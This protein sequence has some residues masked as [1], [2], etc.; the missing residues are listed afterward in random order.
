MFKFPEKLLEIPLVSNTVSTLYNLTS[1]LSSYLETPKTLLSSCYSNIHY[2]T[3]G[4]ILPNLPDMVQEKIQSVTDAMILGDETA[5]SIL[6]QVNERLPAVSVTVYEIYSSGRDTVMGWGQM[7]RGFLNVH[8][9]ETKEGDTVM[10]WGQM[11]RGFLNVHRE[12][13]KEGETTVKTSA[14]MENI[15]DTSGVKKIDVEKVDQSNESHNIETLRWAPLS[16]CRLLTTLEEE[17]DPTDRDESGP[18]PPVSPCVPHTRVEPSILGE[19]MNKMEDVV[20]IDLAELA[21][22]GK[23]TVYPYIEGTNKFWSGFKNMM[24]TKKM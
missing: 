2:A 7:L 16:P 9:E 23:D 8:R 6:E 18:S 1:P 20:G 24:T 15:G 19:A 3:R 5:C 17:I 14:Q 4:Y 13:T 10:G 21:E 22:G 11:L 12:E